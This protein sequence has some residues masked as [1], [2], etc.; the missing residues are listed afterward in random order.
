MHRE[1][2][3]SPCVALTGSSID[4]G[5]SLAGVCRFDEQFGRLMGRWVIILEKNC[6]GQQVV[7]WLEI[8]CRMCR[9]RMAM[10]FL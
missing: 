10:D 7:Q 4:G 2:R 3:L 9:V 6:F 1:L 8:M 5:W